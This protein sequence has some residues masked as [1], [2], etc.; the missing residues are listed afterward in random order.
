MS[1]SSANTTP[2]D[3]RPE[4]AVR[5]NVVVITG[6]SSGLGLET[7]R[8]LGEVWSISEEQTGIDP[9]TSS[10]AHA[11]ERGRNDG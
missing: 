8:Q 9:R 4:S 2:P 3:S 6:A 1:A 10:V 7:S 5:H 11:R